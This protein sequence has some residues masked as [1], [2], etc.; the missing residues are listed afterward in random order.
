MDTISK[1]KNPNREIRKINWEEFDRLIDKLEVKINK[2]GEKFDGITGIARGG[3]VVA[4]C[5]S[6]RLNLRFVGEGT[7]I[8][9]WEQI[10]ITDDVVDSGNTLSKINGNYKFKTASLHLR[11]T[12][13]IIP[14]F[15]VK[16]IQEEWV[17]Y[18]WED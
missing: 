11:H 2:S 18:P 10:L 9:L 4:I 7:R 3:L 12:S 15:Y 14:D 13:K 17:S 16:K 8:N 5:L 1:T 6:H